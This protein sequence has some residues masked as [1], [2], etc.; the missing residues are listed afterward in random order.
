MDEK[1]EIKRA[2][3]A[4][5]MQM[6][7]EGDITAIKLLWNYLE[8]MPIQ[9]NELGGVDGQPIN[10]AVLAGLGFIPPDTTID[11]TSS[12]D[13]AKLSAPLQGHSVAQTSKKDDDSDI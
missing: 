7:L 9:K 4:K 8:G 13:N 2:L 3:G 1:P 11:A 5:I 10:L 12:G 6:A